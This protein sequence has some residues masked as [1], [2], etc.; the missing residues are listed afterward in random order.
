MPTTVSEPGEAERVPSFE[1]ACETHQQVFFSHDALRLYWTLN[2]S[3]TSAISVMD[4]KFY[5]PD[6]PIAQSP[7][8]EPKT[9]SVTVGVEQ[10]DDWK[11]QWME[12][13]R[14]HAIPGPHNDES[15]EARFGSLSD[16]DSDSEEGPEHLLRCCR[17]DRPRKTKV[18]L[19]VNATK[20]FLT[21]HDYVSAVH[22]WLLALREKILQASGDLQDNVPLPSDTKLM[23]TSYLSPDLLVTVEEERWKRDKS[24]KENM[25][26]GQQIEAWN[27]QRAQEDQELWEQ[28]QGW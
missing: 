8:T 24:K 19:T 28:E 16:F 11:D 4:Y 7:L 23:I 20:G 3:L 14:D 27:K 9:S 21:V 10:L 5:D 26:F 12:L 1:A 13:H 15:D 25:K 2:G 22:P 18:S 17:G 6:S